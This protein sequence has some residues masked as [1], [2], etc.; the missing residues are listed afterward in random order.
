[1]GLKSY[2]ASAPGSLIIM[3]EHSV[4]RGKLAIV[5]AI[6]KR[7]IVTLQPNKTAKI[8]INSKDLG[9]KKYNL[10]KLA[11]QKPFEFV[12]AAILHYKKYF[13]STSGFN[14]NIEADCTST[15]G[16]G[17]SAAVTVATV[18]V[19][20]EFFTQS[21]IALAM[22]FKIAKKTMLQVQTVGSGADLAASV[23]G[24]VVAYKAKPSYIK[25]LP[26]ILPGLTV[27]YSGYKT[28]TV[29]VIKLTERYLQSQPSYSNFIFPTMDK[30]AKQAVQ[31]I[32]LQDW[33]LLGGLFDLQQGLLKLLNVSDNCLEQIIS[34]LRLTENIL[35]AK[36]SGSGLGDCVIGLGKQ[37]GI[38]LDLEIDP[39]GVVNGYEDV[40]KNKEQA[41]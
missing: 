27:V 24:G 12:L 10:D 22:L 13:T 30:L 15:V 7:I 20:H 39:I 4:L 21:P 16:L 6:N 41:R 40:R 19:L 14:L 25:K 29:T 28:K 2:K 33:K 9:V 23:Y 36:I 8:I 34:Q 3:G 1:M 17:T 38:G 32:Y 5:T 18:A 26:H 31:A 37:D 11:P 35:G